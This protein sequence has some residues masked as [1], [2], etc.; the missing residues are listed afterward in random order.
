MD[1]QTSQ[2]GSSKPSQD[3]KNKMSEKKEEKLSATDVFQ[4]LC[5][6]VMI[7]FFIALFW[8]L[9]GYFYNFFNSLVS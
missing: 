6:V 9:I 8:F 3:G 5:A 4:A 7:A 1:S 2:I